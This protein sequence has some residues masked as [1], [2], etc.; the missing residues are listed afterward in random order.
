MIAVG[1]LIIHNS[2]SMNTDRAS[3]QG[4]LVFQSTMIWKYDTREVTKWHNIPR[5]HILYSIYNLTGDI[6]IIKISILFTWHIQGRSSKKECDRCFIIACVK[7]EL[8]SL[9]MENEDCRECSI[10]FIHCIIQ[11]LIKCGPN[12]IYNKACTVHVLYIQIPLTTSAWY[13]W[14]P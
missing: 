9:I 12:H 6:R 3:T 10:Y 14:M 7:V 4:S 5:L 1:A 13:Y 8:V 2:L 11:I